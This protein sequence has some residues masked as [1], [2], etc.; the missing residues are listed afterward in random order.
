MEVLQPIITSLLDTDLYKYT[1]QQAMRLRYPEAQAKM[2]FRCRSGRLNFS[3][4]D[5]RREVDA[6]KHLRLQDEELQWLGGLPFIKPEFVQWLK[7]FS[8]DP[9]QVS[10]SGSGGELSIEVSG[11]WA[12]ITH[13]E[14]FILAIVS[15]LHSRSFLNRELEH[16]GKHRLDD[17]I[18]FL[19]RELFSSKKGFGL[20]DF[21][22]RRRCSG[23]WH[24]YVVQ[25]LMTELDCFSGT[26]NLHL[27]RTLGLKPVGTMAH[28]WLQAHQ[29]VGSSLLHSQKEALLVWLDEYG[30]Q[31]GIAL[32]DTISMK[33]FLADFDETMAHAYAGI[34]H[35]SGDPVKW[36]ELALAHYKK[37]GIDAR[38]KTFV[39]SDKL[40]FETAVSIYRHFEGRVNVN[41]GIGTYLTNDLGFSAPNIVLKL[42]EVNGLPVAKLSDNPEKIMCQD[43]D[44]VQQLK[45]VFS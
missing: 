3:L 17:K 29:A 37:L 39:F 10:I 26:S 44:F 30:D 19:K 7:D 12:E 21:G 6:L 41:F 15:E 25:K 24:T 1:M 16:E 32:T 23:P 4:V 40:D 31:L 33:A 2:A 42:V 18:H 20:V 13:F 45:T 11:N 28:E 14:I 35:D 36:G 5:L 43:P 34:R 22:T 8:L 38:S 27:A 9:E